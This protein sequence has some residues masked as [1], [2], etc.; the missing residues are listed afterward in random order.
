MGAIFFEKLPITDIYLIMNPPN[1]H[2]CKVLLRLLQYLVFSRVGIELTMF[3]VIGTDWIVIN[4]TIIRSRA[5]QPLNLLWNHWVIY[6]PLEPT[7]VGIFIGWP[8]RMFML[9]CWSEEVHTRN[10]RP[11]VSFSLKPQLVG[12]FIGWFSGKF[13]A[14]SAH[15]TKVHV[16]FCDFVV[17]WRLLTFHIWIFSSETPFPN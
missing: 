5:Q 13:N 11:K 12:V 7:L 1:D 4:P 2:S 9:F 16:I 14:F 10:K 17:T 6:C 3:V 15:L 8:S